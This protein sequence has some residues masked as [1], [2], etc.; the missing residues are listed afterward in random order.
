VIENRERDYPI[1][2]VEEIV[3]YIARWFNDRSWFNPIGVKGEISEVKVSR[4][5]A[6]RFDLKENR[7]IIA[8]VA[9]SN[10]RHNLPDI[11][12]GD[13]VI[14][15][16]K[17]GIYRDRGAFSLDVESIELTGLG[18]LFFHYER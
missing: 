11:K 13:S 18:E 6:L 10:T 4:D 2:T 9:W 15:V 8:C 3:N 12:S 5:G 17:L 16:G 7:A 14:V 1:R